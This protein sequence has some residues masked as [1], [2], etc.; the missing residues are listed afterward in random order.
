MIKIGIIGCGRI[1]TLRHI[2]ECHENP[3]VKLVGFYNRTK[4]KAALL[5][6]KYGG[7]VYEKVGDCIFDL[8]V[9]A[10]LIST[11][12]NRHASIAIRA[13]KAGKHVICEKP[14]ATS[15]EDCEQMVKAARENHRILLIAYHERLSKT[16]ELAK[17]M[18]EGGILGTVLSFQ[19]TFAHG[20]PDKKRSEKNLWFYD[21]EK[22]GFGVS[23]D[24]GVHKIDTMR[25]LLADEV[26]EVSAKIETINKECDVDDNAIYLVKMKS[27]VIGT[28]TV[29]WTCFGKEINSTTIF[30]TKGIMKIDHPYSG[31][32]EII[33]E[34]G[35]ERKYLTE[36]EYR[37]NG[38]VD[39]GIVKKLIRLIEQ[40]EAE[41]GADSAKTMQVVFKGMESA[42]EGRSVKI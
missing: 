15:Q 22:A 39:S 38:W 41:D 1:A 29:S 17:W 32:V 24:L 27:G 30:G 4:E 10:V 36:E 37:S 40:E 18:I 33:M 35:K 2:P 34:D 19:S 8:D 28:I 23:A 16:H 13:L 6:E 42:A 12:N 14:M 26:D 31:K 11:P 3:D 5:A 21:K 9:D 20:G 7:K 25:Y